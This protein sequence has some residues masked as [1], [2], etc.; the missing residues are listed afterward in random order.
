MRYSHDKDIDRYV[1]QLLR[2]GW[3]F[4]R[5]RKHGKLNA[6]GSARFVTVPG[7]PGDVRTLDNM[8]RDVRR[9]VREVALQESAGMW[10]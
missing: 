10:P 5:G 7:T 6:P 2:R 8:K 1:L 9:L 3:S 4:R